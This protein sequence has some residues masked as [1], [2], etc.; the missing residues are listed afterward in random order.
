[1]ALEPE[2]KEN[3]PADPLTEVNTTSNSEPASPISGNGDSEKEIQKDDDPE[4]ERV[5]REELKHTQSYATD[6]SAA[7][8]TT[9]RATLPV[10]KPW[11]KTPN[12]L[13]WGSIPPVP[14]E[15]QVSREYTAG[16]FSK[17]TFQWMAPLMNV[18][19]TSSTCIFPSCRIN[20]H[21]GWL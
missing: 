13:R 19:I 21:P 9:S 4:R 20:I 15:R 7:T 11:Y 8:R 17:L 10:P 12:P 14:K 18:N 6:T 3:K 1:M 2:D 5:G 16:F